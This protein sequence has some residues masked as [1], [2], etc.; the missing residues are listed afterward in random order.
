MNG[1]RI[2]VE[3]LWPRGVSKDEAAIHLWLKDIAP[4]TGLRKRYGHDPAKWG[5]LRRRYRVELDARSDVID[6][7]RRRTKE[8]PVTFI[9]AAKDEQH[10]SAVALRE[11]LE[12][13]PK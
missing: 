11:Y 3:R 13:K 10:N 9:Y 7:L 8:G 4:S 5:E 2:L 12:G 6:D 1:T